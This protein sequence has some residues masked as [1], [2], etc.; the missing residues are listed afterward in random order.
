MARGAADGALPR[1]RDAREVPRERGP[2]AGRRADLRRRRPQAR[3][4]LADGPG[5]AARRSSTTTARCSG[6]TRSR[7]PGRSSTT[8]PTVGYSLESQTKPNFDTSPDEATLAHE[9]SHQWFGDAVTLRAWPD[10]WLHEG[11]AT[12]A[13]WLWREHTGQ[14]SAAQ[15]FKE[16]YSTR[17][18]DTSFWTPPPGNPGDAAH[19]FDGTI[20][21][22]GG[23]TLQALRE[24][25]GDATFFRLL[26]DWYAQHQ[27]RNDRYAGL[28]RAGLTGVR[29]G[30]EPLLRRVALPAGQTDRLVG[31][32]ASAPPA[33]GPAA[34][35]PGCWWGGRGSP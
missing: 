30:P 1:D 26:R 25:I 11:F 23:M 16:L 17:A 15:R 5:E 33:A 14:K 19:L 12:F 7:T 6:P 18:S 9:L 21:D 10:I 13:E 31:P 8:R 4:G 34:A 35:L 22:R 2:H 24:K 27:L 29:S 28:H 32:T 3:L 20:Y